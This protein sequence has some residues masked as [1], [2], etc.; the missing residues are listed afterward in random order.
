MTIGTSR[1]HNTALRPPRQA[2]TAPGSPVF[3][4]QWRD[5]PSPSMLPLAMPPDG[6]N[7]REPPMSMHYPHRV[8]RIKRKRAIGFRAR[9]KSANGRKLLNR[10]RRVG[11]SLNVA[12]KKR[13]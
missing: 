9:M 2:K 12:D 11:R 4:A 6:A 7:S 13:G 3:P 10:K 8:S 5:P 1:S